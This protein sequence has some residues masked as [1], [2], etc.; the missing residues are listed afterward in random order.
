MQTGTTEAS[1]PN[2][3]EEMEEKISG[4]KDT[5]EEMDTSVKKILSLKLSWHKNLTN[6]GHYNKNKPKPNIRKAMRRNPA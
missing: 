4:V 5:I 6:L 1:F 3:I 2:G